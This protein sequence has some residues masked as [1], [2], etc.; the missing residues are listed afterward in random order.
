MSDLHLTCQKSLFDLEDGVTYLNCAYMSPLLRS[1]M[2]AGVAG[3]RQKARPYHLQVDDFFQPLE[4]L[5]SLFAELIGCP[6]SQQIALQPSASY[7]L[8]TVC[9]NL[10]IKKG[11]NM[12]LPGGQFPSNVY[13][14]RE[15]AKKKDL[16]I[17]TIEPPSN[18]AHRGCIWNQMILDAVDENTICVAISQCHWADGTLFNLEAIRQKTREC[19][20]ALIVD[21]TQSVGAMPFDVKVIQPDALI[22]AA[23]KFL[24]GPYASALAYFSPEFD[25]GEPLE[26]NWFNRRD[27]HQFQHLVNYQDEYRPGAYRYNMGEAAHFIAVPMLISAIEQLLVW[28]PHAIQEYCRSLV[29]PFL[30]TAEKKGYQFE[31]EYRG[32]HLIGLYLPPEKDV[33]LL[34]ERLASNRVFVSY[35]GDAIRVSPHVYNDTVDLE[36]LELFL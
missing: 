3:L 8:S 5:K 33:D 28:T 17:R 36:T 23:Y 34:K 7:G 29:E 26:Y 35:R 27:S 21:G 31:N 20:A 30:K 13:P 14:F 10:R 16:E 32:H 15:L 12:V 11:G 9:K 2:D 24:L 19:K 4:K 25:R 1:T 6:N 18:F 22:C